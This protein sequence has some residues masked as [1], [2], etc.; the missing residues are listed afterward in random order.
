[1]NNKPYVTALLSGTFDILHP[2]HERLIDAAFDIAD[3]VL[4]GIMSDS[5]VQDT[6]P[7]K[8]NNF[9]FRHDMVE[10][11]IIDKHSDRTHWINE[12]E[13]KYGMLKSQINIRGCVLVVSSE[14]LP[15]ATEINN[16][17]RRILL[18]ELTILAIPLVLDNHGHR[19]SSTRLRMKGEKEKE[20]DNQ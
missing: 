6:K 19:Y 10:S 13:D 2:G 5:Y 12:I 1:M 17:R 15:A 14:T 3:D 8:R 18:D 16:F 4:V 20:N 9:Q 11:Y 7:L